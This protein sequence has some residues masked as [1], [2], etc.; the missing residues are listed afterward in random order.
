MKNDCAETKGEKKAKRKIFFF[1]V[2][3]FIALFNLD[4]SPFKYVIPARPFLEC[5]NNQLAYDTCVYLYV[6]NLIP[7]GLMP[8]KDAFDHKGPLLYLM[9]ALGLLIG[10]VAGVWVLSIGCLI[11]SAY[12]AYKTAR[13]LVS[14][15]AASLA[16]SV[17]LLWYS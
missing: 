7:Q 9:M 13:L 14:P 1:C 2:V 6:G 16:A 5:P 10:N 8:Y 4:V 17:S 15:W 3:L 11:I 12:Y